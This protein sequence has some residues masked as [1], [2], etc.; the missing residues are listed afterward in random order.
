LIDKGVSH[1]ILETF[2]NHW[3]K[4]FKPDDTDL[5]KNVKKVSSY[6]YNP[7]NSLLNKTINIL[8]SEILFLGEKDSFDLSRTLLLIHQSLDENKKELTLDFEIYRRFQT[9]KHKGIAEENVQELLFQIEQLQDDRDVLIKDCF[10]NRLEYLE[11]GLTKIPRR[12]GTPSLTRVDALLKN[13]EK[14]KNLRSAWPI[15]RDLQTTLTDTFPIWICRKQAVPFLFPPEGKTFDLV[16]VDEA[17]QCRVD[18]A[19]S[20]FLRGD[21]LMAVGDDKQT[22]L[23]KKSVLDDYLFNEFEL[24]EPLRLQQGSERSWIKPLFSS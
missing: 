9:K 10:I 23:E 15:L 2:E 13:L 14:E 5:K 19:L 18:D 20:I 11:Y 12:G 8:D 7:A 21:R 17:T 22:V 1:P 24:D 16:V 6:I 3:S 4:Y